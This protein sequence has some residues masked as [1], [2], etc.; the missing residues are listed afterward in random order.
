M[1]ISYE[2]LLVDDL[3][4]FTALQFELLKEILKDRKTL[5]FFGD[6]DQAIG[7]KG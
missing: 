5:T 1:R 6:D 2:H 4:D 7:R 3:Q